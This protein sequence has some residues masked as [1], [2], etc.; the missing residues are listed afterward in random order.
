[1]SGTPPA[2][3]QRGISP[4][5][6]NAK[7]LVSKRLVAGVVVALMAAAI[8]VA[9]WYSANPPDEPVKEK[10]PASLGAAVPY[11]APQMIVPPRQPQPQQTAT[12][13]AFVP[14]ALPHYEPLQMQ[15][16]PPAPRIGLGAVTKAERPK[17]YMLTYVAPAAAKP[18]GDARAAGAGGAPGEAEGGESKVNYAASV[19]DGVKAGLLGD[20]T[21]LLMPGL[22]PCVM[23]TAINSTFEGPIQCHVPADIR[24]HGVTLLGRGSIVHG[25]YSNKIQE[26][27]TRLFAQVDWVH[28]PA[29]G[30]FI[31]FDNAPIADG[32][33]QT[34][35]T[36]SV[37]QRYLQRF[38]AA[39]LITIGQGGESLAQAA[40]S[41]GGNTYLNFNGGSNGLDT[42]ATTILRKQIDIPPLITTNQGSTTSVFVTKILDFSPCYDLKVKRG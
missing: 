7:P 27:Q 16:L 25:Y 36:G 39:A 31:K 9:W 14:P 37:D 42:L 26:A 2:G 30:C 38:G 1:M 17:P 32:V 23:D 10:L 19:V 8:G 18:P 13:A 33:G 6:G 29:S 22:M 3:G 4:V 11:T 20:Q 5:A 40:L 34:G 15:P 12:A 24:P 21:F 35:M 28:D 41:K